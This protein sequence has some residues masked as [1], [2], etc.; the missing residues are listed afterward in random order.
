MI[1]VKI[2]PEVAGSFGE[3]TEMDTSVHPPAVSHIHH[4]FQGWLG[5]DVLEVF[6]CFLVTARLA[7]ALA[8]S[9]LTGIALAE[10]EVSASDEF[11]ELQPETELPELQW[12]QI[13]A[14]SPDEADFRLAP[15]HRLEVS[16]RA[17]ALLQRFEI[18]HATV[19]PTG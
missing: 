18:D 6:P 7:K 11:E 9:Q 4:Q 12:L 15:D 19:E 16:E 8:T 2:S 13:T 14:S 17:L 1:Y 3:N 10:A 5:D